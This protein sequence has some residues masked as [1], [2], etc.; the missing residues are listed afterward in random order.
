MSPN[1]QAPVHLLPVIEPL[2][3]YQWRADFSLQPGRVELE[4][5]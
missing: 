2:V 4:L 1:A 3:A 5:T